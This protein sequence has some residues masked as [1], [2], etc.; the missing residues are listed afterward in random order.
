MPVVDF[1]EYVGVRLSTTEKAIL[2]KLAARE[3]ASLSGMVRQCIVR[4]S[5]R[6]LF[7][8]VESQETSD[9]T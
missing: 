9:G 8:T 5:V 4:E 3:G 2:Q 1:P 6:P 7:G